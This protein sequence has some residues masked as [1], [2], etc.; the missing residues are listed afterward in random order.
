MSELI[1]EAEKMPYAP[2]EQ[3]KCGRATIAALASSCQTIPQSPGVYWVVVPEGMEIHFHAPT[4]DELLERYQPEELQRVYRE[5]KSPILYIG[6]AGGK[7]GL[8]QRL[9][10]YM[11]AGFHGGKN[12]RGGRSIWQVDHA[13]QLL[14][15]YKC[16]DS[17]ET[18]E[19]LERCL[20]EKFKREHKHYPVANHRG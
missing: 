1:P 9:R 11:N 15:E 7:R 16:C 13:E 12:H 14:I 2:K 18:C 3:S 19:E 4:D 6:K 17:R 20:L 8:R 5:N 10:Q